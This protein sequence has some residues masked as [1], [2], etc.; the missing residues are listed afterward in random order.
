NRQGWKQKKPAFA[1][2]AGYGAA[3][4]LAHCTAKQ[5]DD[6]KDSCKE[7]EARADRAN[8]AAHHTGSSGP[9]EAETQ[10]YYAGTETCAQVA[11]GIGRHRLRSQSRSHGCEFSAADAT[12]LSQARRSRLSGCDRHY[13]R[14]S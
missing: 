5:E 11:Q 2:F 8:T 12:H 4:P 7:N 14:R 6:R 9:K 10:G 3:S 1:R 13:S